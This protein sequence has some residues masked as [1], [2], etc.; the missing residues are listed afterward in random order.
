MSPARPDLLV[1]GHLGWDTVVLPDRPPLRR[2]G[3]ALWH[4]LLGHAIFGGQ[5]SASTWAPFE[6]LTAAAKSSALT[7]VEWSSA[8][9]APT[10]AEFR[11]TY[12]VDTLQLSSIDVTIPSMPSVDK[13]IGQ[14]PRDRVHICTM[15][16]QDLSA[17]AIAV[18]RAWDCQLSVQLHGSTLPTVAEWAQ[19]TYLHGATLFMSSSEF[20]SLLHV[21]PSTDLSEVPPFVAD[22]FY[23]NEWVITEPDGVYFGRLGGLRRVSSVRIDDVADAT[24]AGDILAGAVVGL[25]AVERIDAPVLRLA[26]AVAGYSLAG[27]T[28]ECLENLLK[29]RTL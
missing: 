19:A 2:M 5:V 16:W 26:M 3:G 24:G 9:L 17:L 18:T 4:F 1:I 29:A 13:L 8:L 7:N 27:Y 22:V 10:A 12:A 21:P 25:S 11:M 15:P 23:L 6:L 14:T 20:E 28:S